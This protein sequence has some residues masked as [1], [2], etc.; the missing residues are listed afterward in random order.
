VCALGA[1]HIRVGIASLDG[2][3][4]EHAH[5]AWDIAHGPAQTIDTAGMLVESVE[6]VVR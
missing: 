4:V 6:A 2:D 3:I 5:R 1:L